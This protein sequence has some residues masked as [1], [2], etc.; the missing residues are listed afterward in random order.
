MDIPFTQEKF[1]SQSQTSPM[2]SL[3]ASLMS[4]LRLPGPC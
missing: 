1:C 3:G 4:L 2:A